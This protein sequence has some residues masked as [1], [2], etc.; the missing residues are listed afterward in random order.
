M[1]SLT[2]N[3][4]T[5][6]A[7]GFTLGGGIFVSFITV[8]AFG[9]AVMI[10]H[11]NIAPRCT[12]R[13]PNTIWRS[14]RDMYGKNHRSKKKRNGSATPASISSSSREKV[15]TAEQGE[16]FVHKNISILTNSNNGNGSS[17]RLGIEP[18]TATNHHNSNGA[19][20]SASAAMSTQEHYHE[21][22]NN[23]NSFKNNENGSGPIYAAH[24]Q[25]RG[26]PFLGWIPWTL[27]LSYDRMLRGIPG[28]GTLDKGMGG[29]LL[30]VNLDAIVLFRYHGKFKFKWR[31]KLLN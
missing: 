8:T 24:P 28:T 1:S 22:N 23:S 20:M 19:A 12:T 9:I 6:E 17:G 16:Q 26:N 4:I 11:T 21:N 15:E 18:P 30:G 10:R 25:D 2:S 13:H 29:K 31:W 27:N 5:L 7:I 3:G 14:Q